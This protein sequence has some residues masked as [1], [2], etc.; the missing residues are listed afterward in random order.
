MNVFGPWAE[1]FKVHVGSQLSSSAHEVS[2]STSENWLLGKDPN[3]DLNS[4]K[5]FSCG[6]L[7]S[8]LK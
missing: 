2:K 8:Y 3:I 5:G 7:K 6:G 4:C 1:F